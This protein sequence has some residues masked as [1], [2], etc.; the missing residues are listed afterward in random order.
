M[1]RN[2]LLKLQKNLAICF[3]IIKIYKKL[4][5]IKIILIQTMISIFYLWKLFKKKQK[6]K[7]LKNQNTSTI[8]GK[9]I[10]IRFEPLLHYFK[11][12][13]TSTCLKEDS[14]FLTFLGITLID[15]YV[16]GR[17]WS[18]KKSCYCEFNF[19]SCFR[20]R[21]KFK[22]TKNMQLLYPPKE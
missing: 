5:F 6:G 19:Y 9:K 12:P 16:D 10:L 22:C 4:Y 13:K 3:T 11:T 2:I 8:A 14:A 17:M 18:W 15:S 1:G 7:G 20:H 21:I